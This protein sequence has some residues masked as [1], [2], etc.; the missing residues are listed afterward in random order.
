MTTDKSRRRDARARRRAGR[1][2]A[3]PP[4]VEV[5]ADLLRHL[6]ALGARVAEDAA[7][8]AARAPHRATPLAVQSAIVAAYTR[9]AAEAA[10]VAR[11]ADA[12]Q[13]RNPVWGSG[14][15]PEELTAQVRAAAA[16]LTAAAAV[17]RYAA[18]GTA[19][20]AGAGPEMPP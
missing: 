6:D 1:G 15:I 2:P 12:M 13:E 10:R 8:E 9:T 18:L 3:D 19:P 7:V 11:L 14:R 16:E 17:L 4:P 20:E 5:R